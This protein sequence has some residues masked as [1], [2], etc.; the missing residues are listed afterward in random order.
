MQ[1]FYPPLQSIKFISIRATKYEILFG[2]LTV[3]E[4]VKAQS[5]QDKL[6]QAQGF[7]FNTS[8]SIHVQA[9]EIKLDL[10]F[11]EISLNN[12]RVISS[13]LSTKSAASANSHHYE[14]LFSCS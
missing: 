4:F 11:L 2:Q 10:L 13:H 8:N 3:S 6:E 5:K 9:K 7:C 1:V 14:H 12:E